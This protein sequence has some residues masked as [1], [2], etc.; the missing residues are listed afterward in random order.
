MI[1]PDDTFV[2]SSEASVRLLLNLV[3]VQVHQPR[4]WL[5]RKPEAITLTWTDTSTNETDYE[6]QRRHVQD[7]D[8]E[9]VKIIKTGLVGRSPSFTDTE[10]VHGTNYVYRVRALNDAVASGF[11]E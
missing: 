4:W 6:I 10:I 1:G 3:R 8:F 5:W 2:Y 9:T 11:S 7:V